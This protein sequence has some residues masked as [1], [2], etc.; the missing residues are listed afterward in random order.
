VNLRELNYILIPKSGFSLER[1]ETSRTGRVLR[2]FVEVFAAATTEGQALFVAMLVTGAA[3]VD[4]RYSHLYLVFSGLFGLLVAALLLRPL[5]AI[6]P[7]ELR[8]AVEHPA[9]VVSGE[10]L[11]VTLVLEN[12]GDRPLHALRV[13]GPFLP[14]DGQWD[15]ARPA[16]AALAPGE[17]VRVSTAVRFLV[18][19]ARRLDPFGVA[20]VRPLGLARGNRRPSPALRFTVLPR[21]VPVATL[22]LP[23]WQAAVRAAPMGAARGL[24]DG[25]ELLGV[26]PYRPGDRLRDLHPRAWARHGQPIV[27]EMQAERLRRALVLVDVTGCRRRETVDAALGLAMGLVAFLVRNHVEVEVVGL[28]R[29]PRALAVGERGAGPALAAELL[30]QLEA[31][32]SAEPGLDAA[33]VLGRLPVGAVHAVRAIDAGDRPSAILSELA[34]HVPWVRTYGVRRAARGTPPVADFVFDEPTLTTTRGLLL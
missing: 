30:A 19:G 6:R 18:R 33:T 17:V 9:A 13:S 21:E 5:A 3:G 20:S 8:V 12:T 32:A 11:T 28:G 23:P 34:V 29:A 25:E 27:R 14:W 4:V 15:A 16:V 31:G 26:R 2:P 1:W 7:G 22:P 10:A 24:G